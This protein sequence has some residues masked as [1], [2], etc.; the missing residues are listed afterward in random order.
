MKWSFV[1]WFVAFSSFWSH[2]C[3]LSSVKSA[4]DFQFNQSC[5]LLLNYAATPR[6]CAA[7]N[8]F[9]L[10]NN[11]HIHHLIHIPTC[12]NFVSF[13]SISKG[14]SEDM[15]FI[16]FLI[17][18]KSTWRI[19]YNPCWGVLT[20]FSEKG[21]LLIHRATFSLLHRGFF[22]LTKGQITEKTMVL[23]SS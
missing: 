23:G 20:L 6:N 10:A 3:L 17:F 16:L 5:V 2:G 13:A 18:L 21:L 11:I 7:P 15:L 12:K 19:F 1:H 22:K 4:H 9:H 8:L 14:T